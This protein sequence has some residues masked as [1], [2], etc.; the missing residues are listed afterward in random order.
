[1][2]PRL[3]AT[4]LCPIS[5]RMNP[6]AVATKPAITTSRLRVPVKDPTRLW[7]VIATESTIQAMMME[8]ISPEFNW[9]GKAAGPELRRLRCRYFTLLLYMNTSN[10]LTPKLDKPVNSK[11]P[12]Y[13]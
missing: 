4:Y 5:W 7:Y 11:V 3:I 8:R 1:M 6:V 2:Y 9:G 12:G 13:V 10:E